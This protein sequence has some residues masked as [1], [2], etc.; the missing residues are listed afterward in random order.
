MADLSSW[1]WETG[2]CINQGNNSLLF[3]TACKFPGTLSDSWFPA[4]TVPCPLNWHM[5]PKVP[6]AQG[7][8]GM[9]SCRAVNIVLL[10]S[11][12]FVAEWKKSPLDIL[13]VNGFHRI[14]YPICRGKVGK[15]GFRNQAVGSSMLG[16]T[17]SDPA[18]LRPGEVL[19]WT[20]WVKD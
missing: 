3:K 11:Q 9:A 18:L 1:L 5:L 6:A 17:G 15:K 10:I 7:V 13:E 4:L 8:D 20:Q 16:F 19:L 2:N 12:G 14:P